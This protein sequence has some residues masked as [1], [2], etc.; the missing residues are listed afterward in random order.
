ML[1]LRSCNS[2]LILGKLNAS[3]DRVSVVFYGSISAFGILHL[4][5]PKCYLDG[6]EPILCLT[7][8]NAVLT[9]YFILTPSTYLFFSKR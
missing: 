1:H 3:W 7:S 9:V 8:V 2:M 5:K 6:P 4:P